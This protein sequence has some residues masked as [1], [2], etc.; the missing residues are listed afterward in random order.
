MATKTK[1]NGNTSRRNAIKS[2]IALGASFSLNRIHAFGGFEKEKS[3]EGSDLS[4]KTK[5]LMTAFNLKYPI[6]Q[7][8]PGGE[9]L[10]ITL[11]NAGAMGALSL[12][13][14][15]PGDTFELV[16]KMKAATKGN[17]YGNYVLNF[18]PKSLDK[19]LEAGIPCVQFSWAYPAKQ[20]S[21]KLKKQMQSW[22]SRLQ[23]KRMPKQPWSIT[24]IFLYV[25]VWR[26]ADMYKQMSHFWIH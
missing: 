7:A 21:Q 17:F 25:R 24:P 15:S 4:E 13:W 1:N 2:G 12:T 23:V 8:A 9:K 3:E 26:R 16:T 20:S 19:A 22:A 5:K 10:A 14:A 11:A 6:F 18:E